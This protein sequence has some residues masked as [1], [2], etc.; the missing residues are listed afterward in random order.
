MFTEE[1][2][3]IA[4]S[5]SPFKK[6]VKDEALLK[7]DSNANGSSNQFHSE[8][9]SDYLTNKLMPIFPFW[10][11]ILTGDL[12]RHCLPSDTVEESDCRIS[13]KDKQHY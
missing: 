6:S 4:G 3:Q 7:C 2:F 8:T 9:F 1:E 12:S 13:P 10:S 11:S 5:A